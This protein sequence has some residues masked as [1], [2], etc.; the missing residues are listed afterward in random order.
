MT[1]M[2]A[3]TSVGLVMIHK[4]FVIQAD[5]LL[6]MAPF[7]CAFVACIWMFVDSIAN[8]SIGLSTVNRWSWLA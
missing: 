7:D 8:L 5:T 3:K 2:M 1:Q 6:G 4:I